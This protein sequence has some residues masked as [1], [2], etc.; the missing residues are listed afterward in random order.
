MGDEGASTATATT[1]ARAAARRRLAERPLMQV[2]GRA[3]L[4]ERLPGAPRRARDDRHPPPGRAVRRGGQVA[5]DDR[6]PWP[7]RDWHA[8]RVSTVDRPEITRIR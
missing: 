4:L 6:G 8:V 2:P 5:T 3:E 7:G 1:T